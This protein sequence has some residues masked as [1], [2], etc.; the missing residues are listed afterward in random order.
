MY[1]ISITVSKSLVWVGMGFVRQFVLAIVC[2]SNV[3]LSVCV[4]GCCV[5][6]VH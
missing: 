5:P 3:I 2:A 1:D 4:F 6:F